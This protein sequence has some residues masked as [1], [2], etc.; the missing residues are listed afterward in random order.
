MAINLDIKTLT[1]TRGSLS[2]LE[3]LPFDIKRVYYLHG[4]DTSS[5]RG[6][7]AHKKLERIMMCVSGSFT[8]RARDGVNDRTHKLDTP[9]HGLRIFPMEW[10]ELSDFSE[11]AVCLVLASHEH[12][13]NDCIRDYDEYLDMIRRMLFETK[14]NL[15]VLG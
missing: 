6:G 11:D 7:H 12:D 1:D 14:S 13:E 10:L 5:M 9:T 8:V 15:T 2:V 3:R 4:I